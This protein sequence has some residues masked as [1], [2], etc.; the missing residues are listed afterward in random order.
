MPKWFKR[1]LLGVALGMALLALFLTGGFVLLEGTPNYYRRSALTAEQRADAAN[2]AESKLSQMQNVAVDAHGAE[3]QKLHGVTQPTTGPGAT[4]FS[5]TDDELNALFNKWAELNNW[6]DILSR[7]VEDPMIV[8]NDGRIIFAGKVT[9]KNINTVV[10]IEFAPAITP[11]GRLDLKL[12]SILGGKLPLPTETILAPIRRKL[13][14]EIEQS[15]PSMQERAG[16]TPEG[17]ANEAAAKALYCKLLF[18]TLNDQPSP[19][20]VFLPMLSSHNSLEPFRL[21]NVSIVDNTLSFTVVPMD[22]QERT[23]LLEQI[24]QPIQAPTNP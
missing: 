22:S 5:F 7:V 4:T 18:N 6:K 15:L 12:T 23:T 10:S 20:A 3:V 8:L 9:V 16:I 19:S 1:F 21:S 11:D 24:K 14:A 2:R 13:D 17:G